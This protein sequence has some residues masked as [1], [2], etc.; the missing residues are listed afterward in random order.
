MSYFIYF[1]VPTGLGGGVCPI[2]PLMGIAIL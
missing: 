1:P 2:E